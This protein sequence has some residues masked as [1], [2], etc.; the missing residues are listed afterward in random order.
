MS[1]FFDFPALMPDN[2]ELLLRFSFL[3]FILLM[4]FAVVCA[5]DVVTSIVFMSL[6]S[7]IMSIMYLIMDAPDVAI[8]EA[9]IGACVTTI[10]LLKAIEYVKNHPSDNKTPVKTKITGL[11]AVI[12]VGAGLFYA[13]QDVLYYG[14]VDAPIHTEVSDYYIEESGEDIGIPAIAA[15]ILAS[16]RGYDTLGETT[17]ILT[18]GLSVMLLLNIR[19][20]NV[21]ND[22]ID[23]STVNH[24]EIVYSV[25][26]KILTPVILIY[27]IYIQI[28]GEQSPGGG[29]QAGAILASAFILHAL[30]FGY[31]VT[32]KFIPI[33]LLKIAACVGVLIYALVGVASLPLGGNYL[34][35]SWLHI[36]PVKGEQLG[37]MLV[38]LGVGI[39][40]FS[41]LMLIYF[42]F[43]KR[44]KLFGE[45]V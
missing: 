18:A 33:K 8:T 24:K 12:M 15:S 39:T 41:V 20:K 10:L 36:D 9:A 14:E 4:S 11:I 21:P 32:V 16:Y 22:K 26:A 27:A 29:F 34:D 30:L 38:E 23:Y 37:I 5:K 17:V 1:N 43:E 25:I 6:L 44:I 45:K 42:M 28:F 7:L 3:G 19:R 35:Y 13:F 31:E 40:V 2:I